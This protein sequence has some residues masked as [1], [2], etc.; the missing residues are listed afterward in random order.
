[1]PHEQV[2]SEI[3]CTE[4]NENSGATKRTFDESKAPLVLDF[5]YCLLAPSR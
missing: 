2:G 4:Q 3:S 1:M 5:D